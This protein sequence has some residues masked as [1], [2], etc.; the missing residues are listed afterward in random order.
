[1]SIV[2]MHTLTSTQIIRLLSYLSV[3]M[4]GTVYYSD[5]RLHKM[6]YLNR[7]I[8]NSIKLL[9]FIEYYMQYAVMLTLCILD[10]IWLN[11]LNNAG[12][13]PKKRG[14]RRWCQRINLT[15]LINYNERNYRYVQTELAVSMERGQRLNDILL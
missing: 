14:E 9:L 4:C 13:F 1:M 8:N 2:P 12:F 10:I 15:S 5:S 3:K 11:K 6:C 7:W